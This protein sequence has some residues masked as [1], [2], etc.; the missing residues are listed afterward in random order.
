MLLPLPFWQFN[1][2]SSAI[3]PEILEA[4]FIFQKS[5]FSVVHVE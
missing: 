4:L 3:V 1:V 5:V 2:R